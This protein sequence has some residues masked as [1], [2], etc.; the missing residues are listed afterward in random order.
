MTVALVSSLKLNSLS[1]GMEA[2][3]LATSTLSKCWCLNTP[4]WKTLRLVL[5]LDSRCASSHRPFLLTFLVRSMRR[6]TRLGS[7][8]A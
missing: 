2:K 7:S 6:A 8:D 4:M 1:A 3:N 5:D